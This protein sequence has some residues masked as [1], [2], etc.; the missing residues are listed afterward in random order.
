MAVTEPTDVDTSIPESWSKDIL[1]EHRYGNFWERFQGNAIVQK[2]E[3]LNAPGDLIHI[4]VT[5]PLS[6]T[7]VEGDTAVLEGQ[8]EDLSTTE[9]KVSPILYRHAVK[10][11]RRAQKKSIVDL[12]AEARMRLSEWGGNKVDTLRFTN[13]RATAL[14][15]P[16]NAETY[17]PRPFLPGSVRSRSVRSHQW[18]N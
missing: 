9:I 8:E 15:A 2:T 16:L 7:G 10:N 5:D 11:N 6:G 17:A 18:L 1:R 3:L 13:F 14:P 4:Q 12:M